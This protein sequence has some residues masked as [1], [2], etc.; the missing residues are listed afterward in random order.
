MKSEFTTLQEIAKP[1]CA[2]SV[3]K[4]WKSVGDCMRF[5]TT[6]Y[7]DD[8]S[9]KLALV[10][11]IAMSADTFEQEIAAGATPLCNKCIP[12]KE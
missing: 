12:P 5:W 7:E 2:L 8:T 1:R 3:R 11:E 4:E 10:K 9:D 6:D